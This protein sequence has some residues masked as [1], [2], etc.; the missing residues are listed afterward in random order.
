MQNRQCIAIGGDNAGY[1]C[2]LQS[3]VFLRPPG[4]VDLPGAGRSQ[5]RG[6]VSRP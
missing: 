3:S 6:K 4:E 2:R 1:A 5:R